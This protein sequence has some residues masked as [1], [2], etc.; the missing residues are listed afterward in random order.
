MQRVPRCFAN[1]T[2]YS[3][4][5][6]FPA[7]VWAA[8][9]T[10]SFR[11]SRA[12]ACCWKLSSVNGYVMAGFGM[13]EWKSSIGSKAVLAHDFRVVSFWRIASRSAKRSGLFAVPSSVLTSLSFFIISFFVD[14]SALIS[15]LSSWSTSWSDPSTLSSVVPTTLF[16][17][18]S[19]LRGVTGC[20][21]IKANAVA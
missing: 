18:I 15:S 10:D 2:A 9:N 1:A 11:S 14:F 19:F 3:A 7:D 5:T 17:S 16:S 20:Y 8:T 6:V 13:Y 12:T 4:T 21:D